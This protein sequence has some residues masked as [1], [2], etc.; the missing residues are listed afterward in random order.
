MKYFITLLIT[1]STLT[2]FCQTADVFQ[3]ART[4]TVEQMKALFD[5]NNKS[6]DAV[7]SNGFTPLILA[8]YRSNNEV[9]L[10]L[11]EK[12][13]HINYT[14]KMGSTLMAAIFKNNTLIFD[15][16]VKKGIDL[17]L[18]D[19]NQT[20]ALML[21]VTLQHVEF[22][23]KLIDSGADKTLKNHI[24]KTAFQLAIDTNNQQLIQLFN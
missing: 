9:A 11:I 18:K 8:T 12:T 4:G 24:N 19:D 2:A 3:I 21:A 17:N 15:A 20:T 1:M 10:F 23:K 13:K 14:S 16:L 22:T 7:D 6:I 5:Q